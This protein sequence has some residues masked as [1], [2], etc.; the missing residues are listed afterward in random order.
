LV[1]NQRLPE[2]E[3][4]PLAISKTAFLT[5]GGANSG[6]LDAP[7]KFDDPDLLEI[8][9]TWPTIPEHVKSAILKM[10]KET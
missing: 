3:H 9:T 7:I 6:A 2:F 5:G 10:V 1:A 8:I 4:T